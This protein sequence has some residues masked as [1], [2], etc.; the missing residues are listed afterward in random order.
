M[1]LF[2]SAVKDF[3]KSVFPNRCELCGEVIELDDK[4]CTE[5]ENAPIIKSP[6]C[7]LCGCSEDDCRCKKHKNEY[8]K[9]TAPYYYKDSIIKAVHRFKDGDMPFL[10]KRFSKDMYDLICENYS[11]VSFDMVSFVPLR[12]FREQ[13]RGYNQSQLLAKNIGRL[14]N[15]EVLPLLKKIRNT[16][17]QHYKTA[18]KRRADVFGAYDVREKYK[19]NLDGK[20]V[21]LIDDVKTTGSTLSECAKMLK[22]YGA[23][24]VYC[25]V[26]A[27]TPHKKAANTNDRRSA[28]GHS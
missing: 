14:M 10:A 9:I 21:L 16:G 24:E 23:H 17:V 26:V 2:F 25:A 11:N 3:L 6:V 15:I 12:K 7:E 13:K 5:C 19:N 18:A 27:I 28:M 4:L 8:K 20:T 1:N 22:I